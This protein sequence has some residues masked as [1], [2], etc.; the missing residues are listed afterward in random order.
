[1][2]LTELLTASRI[3][4]HASISSK[5][6]A[7]EHLAGLLATGAPGL[8][9]LEI[10]DALAAREKLGSTGFGDGIAIP[11]ARV[12]RCSGPICA[13]LTLEPPIDF[14]AIDRNDV[15]ILWALI[16]PEQ[17]TDEHLN[18]LAGVAELLG[19]HEHRQSIRAERSSEQLLAFIASTQG[20]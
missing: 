20:G 17:A 9:A 2:S 13:L 3:D 8:D 14:D 16:V 5:K 18:I 10:F 6:K 7:L 4:L 15:D 12:S 19:K 1:M 11:H